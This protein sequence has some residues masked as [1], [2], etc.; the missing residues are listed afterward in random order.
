MEKFNVNQ[1][2]VSDVKFSMLDA[3]LV[4]GDDDIVA[5]RPYSAT[6]KCSS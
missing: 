3:G 6:L 1:S 2:K 4:F 5:D